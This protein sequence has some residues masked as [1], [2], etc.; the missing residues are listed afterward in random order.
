MKKYFF[1][2][3]IEH[4]HLEFSPAF[5]MQCI[6]FAEVVVKTKMMV[7]KKLGNQG[8]SFFL[9]SF[10]KLVITLTNKKIYLYGNLIPLN[11]QRSLDTRLVGNLT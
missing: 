5:Q 11:S 9:F 4:R 2:L 1:L 7:N 8:Q 6:F 3:Y 10:Y